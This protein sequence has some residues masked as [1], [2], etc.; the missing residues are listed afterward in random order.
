MAASGRDTASR[1]AH[2]WWLAAALWATLP[3]A[4]GPALGAALHGVSGPVRAVA[5]VG[6]WTG[7]VVALVALLVRSTVSLT[8]SRLVV[9]G[10]PL[11]C[12]VASF[13]GASAIAAA[14]AVA[15]ALTAAIVAFTA[16][17]GEAFVQGSAYG[18]ERR[19]P[20]RPPA[21]LLLVLPLLWCLLAAA[22]VAGPLLLAAHQWVAGAVVSALALAAAVL[23]APRFHR[24]TRRWLVFVPAGLVLHDPYL[25]A[26]SA[27][28]PAADVADMLLAPAGTEALDLTGGAFGLAVEVRLA[29]TGTLVVA[30]TLKHRQ[31]RGVHVRSFLCSPSR[32]GRALTVADQRRLR[33]G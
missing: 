20:L 17:T 33:A 14:V 13:A 29:E 2:P 6:L 31:G 11:A 19:L 3:V 5:A 4:C 25:L 1:S 18:D 23:L 28:F 8:V 12:V 16:T 15:F 10:A 26:Q 7:W 9:P 21:S 32:P 22:A 30:G 24:L 27:M